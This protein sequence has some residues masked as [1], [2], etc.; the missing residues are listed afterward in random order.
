MMEIKVEILMENV[1]AR[2][3]DSSLLALDGPELNTKAKEG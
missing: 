2:S 1:L 3:G